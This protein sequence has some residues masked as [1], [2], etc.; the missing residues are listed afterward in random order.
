MVGGSKSDLSTGEIIMYCMEGPQQIL[1][2]VQNAKT[3]SMNEMLNE[4]L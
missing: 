1:C 4:R 2:Y 3:G